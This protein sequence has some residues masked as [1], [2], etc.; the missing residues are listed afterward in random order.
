MR[1]TA[2][3]NASGAIARGRDPVRAPAVASRA[4]RSWGVPNFGDCRAI[5]CFA[6]LGR[7]AGALVGRPCQSVQ[8]DWIPPGRDVMNEQR[9]ILAAR[10]RARTIRMVGI[11]M[12]AIGAILAKV[13]TTNI[14]LFIFYVA[15][16]LGGLGLIV[17]SQSEYRKT[18]G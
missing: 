17:H 5:G 12:F 18:L 9:D 7:G 15:L 1:R 8:P 13:G 6:R 3:G 16:A 10:S 2:L 14:G 11:A 4:R